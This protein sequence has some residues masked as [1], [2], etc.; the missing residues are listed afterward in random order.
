MEQDINRVDDSFSQTGADIEIGVA[1]FDALQISPGDLMS[2]PILEKMRT[3]TN[4][5][6][7]KTEAAQVI[8]RVTRSNKSPHLKNIDH[9]TAYVELA[10]QKELKLKEIGVLDN[11]LG[12][13]E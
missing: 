8:K 5:F 1:L 10:K 7:D 6:N 3:I 9:L 12:Y 13:Y 11:E 2:P 4:F